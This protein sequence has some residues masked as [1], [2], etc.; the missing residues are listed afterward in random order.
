VLDALRPR[1]LQKIGSIAQ[2]ELMSGTS[3]IRNWIVVAGAAEHLELDV[4]DYVPAYR[5]HAGTGVGM[6][7]ARWC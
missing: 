5:S 1:D 3:E 6:G 4:V 7:F 2:R